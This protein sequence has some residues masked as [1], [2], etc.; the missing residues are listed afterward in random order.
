MLGA[1]RYRA[2]V[3]PVTCAKGDTS[4][5]GILRSQQ[6]R[7]DSREYR[8][9]WREGSSTDV[10][11]VC[12]DVV[13]MLFLYIYFFSSSFSPGGGGSRWGWS[14]STSTPFL[15]F[16]LFFSWGGSSLSF[17]FSEARVF[18]LA[19]VVCIGTK[20]ESTLPCFCSFSYSFRRILGES[21]MV[22]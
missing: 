1:V 8:Q 9:V 7:D 11:S 6:G 19:R 22:N 5:M 15:I 13:I 10:S 20:T 16:C 12:G 17:G 3:R 18:M 14:A 21:C 2:D 4:L